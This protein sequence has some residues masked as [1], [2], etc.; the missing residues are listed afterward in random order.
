[1]A[2]ICAK[3][4]VHPDFEDCSCLSDEEE[5]EADA[6]DEALFQQVEALKKCPKCSG[7]GRKKCPDCKGEGQREVTRREGR[8]LVT[9]TESCPDCEGLGTLDCPDC[10]GTGRMGTKRLLS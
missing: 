3:G 8:S 1:M 6:Q 9:Q 10:K 7:T 5:A 2:W 4:A